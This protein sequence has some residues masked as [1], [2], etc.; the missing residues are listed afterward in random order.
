MSMVSAL[1]AQMRG[2]GM[3]CALLVI[4]VFLS[5]HLGNDGLAAPDAAGGLA[6]TMGG[7]L[8]IVSLLA[9]WALFA[10]WRDAPMPRP[11]SPGDPRAVVG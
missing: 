8:A 7:A 11:P 3:V 2:L 5:A 10:A 9:L 6:A 1:A 4:T